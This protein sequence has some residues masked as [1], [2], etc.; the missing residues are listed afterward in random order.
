MKADHLS[1]FLQS[2]NTETN[3]KFHAARSLNSQAKY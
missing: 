2:E 1:E 3:K